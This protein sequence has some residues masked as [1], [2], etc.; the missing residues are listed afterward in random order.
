[1]GVK[2]PAFEFVLFYLFPH[3]TLKGKRDFSSLFGFLFHLISNFFKHVPFDNKRQDV[4]YYRVYMTLWWLYGRHSSLCD[5]LLWS[6]FTYLTLFMR[7]KFKNSISSIITFPRIGKCLCH[8]TP[9]Y[10]WVSV[11]SSITKIYLY[12]FLY[13]VLRRKGCRV[14]CWRPGCEETCLQLNSCSPNSC[15]SSKFPG[16]YNNDRK[17]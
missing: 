16:P 5:D 4:K 1:M 2:L 13:A 8:I 10:L 3:L 15:S 14:L 17:I 12:V 11:F 9:V 7:N 6:K